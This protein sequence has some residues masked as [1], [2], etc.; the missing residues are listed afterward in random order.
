MNDLPKQ[1]EIEDA[2]HDEGV[3][4]GFYIN[5]L[6]LDNEIKEILAQHATELAS[7]GPAKLLE[8]SKK[9]EGMYIR[10][11]MIDEDEEYILA[12]KKIDMEAKEKMLDIINNKK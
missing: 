1:K 3:K 7:S 4:I 5:G 9:L 11:K 12:A 10:D 2:I 8:F 6:S